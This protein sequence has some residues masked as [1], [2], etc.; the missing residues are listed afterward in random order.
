MVKFNAKLIAMSLG[1][2]AILK[3]EKITAQHAKTLFNN[4]HKWGVV[5]QYNVFDA[6]NI[7][8]TNNPNI[9]YEIFKSKM[10]ALGIAYNFY[11]YKNWNFKAEL[12]LQWFGNLEGLTILEPENIVPFNYEDLSRTEHDKTGYLPLTAEY[13]F[14]NTGSFSFS[15]GGGLG[16]TYY[17]HYDIEGS[18]GLAINDVTLFEAYERTDYP[19][20]YL[21]NHLQA[22]IYLK[23]KSFMLQTS[24]IYKKSYTSFRTGTYEFKNLKVSPDVK[25][26]FDQSGDFLGISLTIYPKYM[27]KTEKY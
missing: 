15:I 21:S 23:R 26:A 25:G 9:N 22:S 7:T 12:Q 24:L 16:L 17:W 5:I 10:F 6:A 8:P 20:F 4:H 14:L 13:V 11:Q 19:L 27:T 3:T 2:I 1:L 18:S